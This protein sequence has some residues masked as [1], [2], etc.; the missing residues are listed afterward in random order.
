V[1][2]REFDYKSKS[3]AIVKDILFNLRLNSQLALRSYK[4]NYN[5]T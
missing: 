5:T 4:V 3:T 1:V 2:E